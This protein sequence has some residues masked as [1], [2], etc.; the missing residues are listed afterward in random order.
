MRRENAA[1]GA[2]VAAATGPTT[3][4][5]D[6]TLY[7]GEREREPP[8]AAS[9]SFLS[10]SAGGDDVALPSRPNTTT[11]AAVCCRRR[12][13]RHYVASLELE[14]AVH[15]KHL[16]SEDI[17]RRRRH[18]RSRPLPSSMGQSG[19]G[20]SACRWCKA[21]VEIVRCATL[22]PLPYTTHCMLALLEKA[23]ACLGYVSRKRIFWGGLR[24]QSYL[25]SQSSSRMVCKRRW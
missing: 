18:D 9:L 14:H 12:R 21:V 13:H 17:F 5:T 8:M 10:P 16:Y 2:A 11:A 20:R 15:A 19:C 24:G 23:E 3:A 4:P 25:D 6:S 22:L 1:A 7:N